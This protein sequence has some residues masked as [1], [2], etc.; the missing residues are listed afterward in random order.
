MPRQVLF[1]A[2]F[3][4]AVEC[5][6]ATAGPRP[7]AEPFP[8][9]QNGFSVPARITIRIRDRRGNKLESLPSIKLY[10]EGGGI[11][12]SS[13]R[14]S[15]EEV[16]FEVRSRGNYTLEISSPGFKRI[17][18]SA[19][20]SNQGEHLQ[21][22]ITMEAEDFKGSGPAPAG[23]MVL[24]PKAQEELKKGLDALNEKKYSEAKKHLE[25]ALQLAPG[26]PDVNY[27]AGLLYM[28][29]AEMPTAIEHLRKATS[30]NPKSAAAFVAL[31]E[32]LYRGGDLPAAA[33]ALE[34]GLQLKPDLWRGEWLLGS[35]FFQQQQY[36]K[37]LQH[38]QAAI[39]IGKDDAVVAQFLLG[40]C[41]GALGKNK[42]AIAAF[43]FFLAREPNSP[44]AAKAQEY[45]KQLQALP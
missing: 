45:V 18:R 27:I 41:D 19:P 30:L 40:K 11:Y 12:S 34:N 21:F 43:Q 8:A 25:K 35:T 5:R 13:P 42:E 20:I 3:L 28:Q 14:Q 36:E 17:E 33:A 22:D 16:Y 23:A 39:A 29:T 44:Q 26:S 7:E 31:G 32:A 10:E 37:A 9:E 24:A 4:F 6:A 38:V 15:D 1:I 2:L